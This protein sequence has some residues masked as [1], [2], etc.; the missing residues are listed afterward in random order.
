M[1]E[2]PV[3]VVRTLLDAAGLQPPEAEVERLAKLY[4]GLRRSVDRFHA[5]TTADEVPAAVFRA[6]DP[7]QAGGS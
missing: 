2:H 4:P 3:E 6:V 5:V 7:D 1:E